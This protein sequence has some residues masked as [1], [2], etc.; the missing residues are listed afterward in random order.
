MAPSATSSSISRQDVAGA[1]VLLLAA[2]R[3][4]DAERA[5]VVAADRDRHPAAVGGVAAGRKRRGEDVERLED[6]ELRLAVVPGALEQGRQRAHV[7]GAEH[8]VDPGGLV[9]DDALV[10]LGEA[11]ADGDLHAVVLALDAGE[12]TEGAVELV[13][14]VLAHGAG[15]DDDDVGLARRRRRT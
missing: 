15:V 5:G 12:V 4:D 1:A 3:G 14:G 6:L 7:V 10:L 2:Q 13:V 8:D 9:E 11:A